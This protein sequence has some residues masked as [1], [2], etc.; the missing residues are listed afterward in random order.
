MRVHLVWLHHTRQP[1]F[2][3]QLL[4][5]P[6]FYELH[7]DDPTGGKVCRAAHAADQTAVAVAVVQQQTAQAPTPNPNANPNAKPKTVVPIPEVRSC[8]L[9]CVL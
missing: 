3:M 5:A 1:G 6:Y 8:S 4:K 9:C 7:R 2:R